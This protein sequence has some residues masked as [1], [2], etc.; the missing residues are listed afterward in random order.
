MALTLARA[1]HRVVV[2]EKGPAYDQRDFI[3]D[4]IATCRRDFFTPY[5]AED[6]HIL[7]EGAGR[8]RR[9]AEGWTACCVGGGTT[10][11]SGFTYR[12]HPEDLRLRSLLGEVAGSTLADWPIRWEELLPC[13][14][15]M[16]VELGVSGEAGR[17]PF[18]T[19]RQPLPL[20]PLP[21]NGIALLVDEACSKLG[22]HSFPTA[23]AILSRAWQ[24]R[25]RCQ[26]SFF[27]GSY[28]CP[29]GARSTSLSALLPK[30]VATGNC[31]VRPLSMVHTIEVDR[32]GRPLGVLYF[33]PQGTEQRLRAAVVVVACSAVES[34]RLLLHSRSPAHP[35]GLANES[36]LVGRNLMFASFGTG[37]AE[38]SR[39]DARIAAID[40][41]Q[42]FVNRS[43]QDLYL[44][45]RDSP[46]PRKGGTVSFLFP[47]AN[48][49]FTAERLATEAREPLWG[50]ALKQSLR[51]VYREVRELE[52]EV[53]SETLPVAD[54]RV[55]LDP[56]VK[57]RWGVP[58]AR[59][60]MVR[61]PQDP[62]TNRRLVEKGLEVLRTMGGEH[63]RTTRAGSQM[64]VVQGGTCRFGDDPRSSALDRDCRSRSAP[65]LFV[66]DGSVMPTL[67][68]VPNT[69]T[70]EAN[71]LRVGER[72]IA[73]GR[74]HE[75]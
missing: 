16:E 55:T 32:A 60:T 50:A 39:S 43:F 69:L 33:D 44:L 1:G 49:I 7:V 58:A 35:E 52:F 17:N 21:V 15:R 51:R 13:Y 3:H 6:P 2:L 38:F 5:P 54:S 9:S 70:I 34:A 14:E 28:G 12:L 20:P 48:P 30:A 46:Q 31:Q 27:C 24:G 67:G 23:R 73:L 71:A 18:E 36:G 37:A 65:N 75:L 41:R 29:T 4:E 72:I 19:F 11:M 68:G 25:A 66:A 56:K 64:Y 61:H 59:L 22:L 57:D 26:L 63:V 62:E 45:D 74:A 8:P 40:W 42:P 10:H 53:F 47:H